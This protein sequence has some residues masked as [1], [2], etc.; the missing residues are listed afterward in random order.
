L[1]LERVLDADN[2]VRLKDAIQTYVW[3]YCR[4]SCL[5]WSC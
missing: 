4:T 1:E 3:S 5:H 2:D